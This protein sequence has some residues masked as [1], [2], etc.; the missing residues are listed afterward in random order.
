[1]RRVVWLYHGDHRQ[2]PFIP[3]ALDA[4]VAAGWDA[5]IVD[6]AAERVD[7]RYR[8]RPRP[9]AR[10]DRTGV[11]AWLAK[12]WRQAGLWLWMLREAWRVRPAC[13]IATMPHAAAAGW[14]VATVQRARLVY[15]P[16]ELYG[17]QHGSVPALMRRLERELLRRGIDALVTQNEHRARVYVEERGARVA[18]TIVHN[19]KPRRRVRPGGRLRGLLDLPAHVRIVLYEGYLTEG[20]W[21]DRLVAAAPYLPADTRLVLMGQETAWWTRHG[22]ALL[23]DPEIAAHVRVAPCVPHGVVADWVADADVGVIIYDDQVRN[24]VYCEPG[25]LSD[26]VLAGLPVVAPDFPSIGPVIRRLG[27][28]RCFQTPDPKAIA[29]AIRTVL[30][31]PRAVFAPGLARAAA[32]LVWETQVPAFLE[33]VTGREGRLPAPLDVAG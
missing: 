23:R 29:A 7:G 24:N 14:L 2:H 27:I 20:R 28:G 22:A 26:Y 8:H 16:F 32:E 21:L 12:A 18:P 10:I 31:T 6:L 33:A 11:G 19:Y 13:I 4:L 30:G 5:T 9:S 17:E 3:A 1:M 25:K 15:Y